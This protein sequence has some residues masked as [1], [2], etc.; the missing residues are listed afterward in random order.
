MNKV[1]QPWLVGQGNHG[2]HYSTL[3][4]HWKLDFYHTVHI[5]SQNKHIKEQVTKHGVR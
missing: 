5:S 4:I 3:V 2:Q 1:C